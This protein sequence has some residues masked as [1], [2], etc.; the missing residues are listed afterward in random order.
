MYDYLQ[1]LVNSYKNLGYNY[2]LIYWQDIEEK[3]TDNDVLVSNNVIKSDITCY[4]AKS[5]ILQNSDYS[6]TLP[7]DALLTVL[8]YNII[9]L[10]VISRQTTKLFEDYE[11]ELSNN[12]Y[13]FT[14]STL[15]TTSIIVSNVYPSFNENENLQ[16]NTNIGFTNF[17]LVL[18]FITAIFF[19]L[20][21]RF[22]G[23]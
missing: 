13:I 16:I 10:D 12:S 6:F 2:Y 14:N 1:G 17:I 15:D 3:K 21:R 11:I 8:D 18:I 7:D 4:F 20:F 5:P 22:L 23:G 19:L 9:T